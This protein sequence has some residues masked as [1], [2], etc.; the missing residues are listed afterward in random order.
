MFPSS[1]LAVLSP[2]LGGYGDLYSTGERIEHRGVRRTELGEFLSREA[3]VAES[4]LPH[5]PG[6]PAPVTVG[7]EDVTGAPKANG[8][9]RPPAPAPGGRRS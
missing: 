7:P 3:A 6:V 4:V 9:P 1:K 5:T 8:E 2:S